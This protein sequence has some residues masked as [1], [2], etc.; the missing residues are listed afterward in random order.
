MSKVVLQ[1]LSSGSFTVDLLNA[2]FAALAA[3]IENTLSRDG[4]SPNSM[5]NNFDMNGYKILNLGFAGS[6]NEPITKAQLE[7]LSTPV[8]YTPN[9]HTHLW[10]DITNK[11]TTFT[12]ATHTHAQSDVTGL[13][14]SLASL[15]T[16]LNVIEAKPK[17]S[18]QA[19]TPSSPATN[20]LW[21]Y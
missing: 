17:I 8:L 1:T 16:R 6:A 11:P 13:V 10:A 14:A 4:T 20:D 21:F 15:D 18:I 3:A 12:P 7:A 2:N 5:S 19:A 9:P